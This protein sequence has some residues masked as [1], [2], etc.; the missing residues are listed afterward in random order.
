MRCIIFDIW[1]TRRGSKHESHYYVRTTLI[2]ISDRVRIDKLGAP[3]H[4]HMYCTHVPAVEC[5]Y[6]R[7]YVHCQTDCRGNVQTLVCCHF[8]ALKMADK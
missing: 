4:V 6:I 8:I 7:T 5:S 3:A 1:H 2:G